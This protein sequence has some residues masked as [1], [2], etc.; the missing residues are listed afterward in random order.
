MAWTIAAKKRLRHRHAQV[1][2]CRQERM[3]NHPGY[4]ADMRPME[5]TVTRFCAVALATVWLTGAPGAAALDMEAVN[6]AEPGAA[7]KSAKSKKA[8]KGIDAVTVKAQILLDRARFSPGEID[9]RDGENMRKALAAFE[10]ANGLEPDG[11]LDADVWARLTETTSEPVLVEYTVTDADV[12][13][14]FAKKIPDKMEDMQDLE[15]LGYRTPL[16][17]LA[18]KFHMSEALMK[19]LN[20]GKKFDKGETIVVARVRT[21]APAGKATRIEIDKAHKTLTVHGKDGPL[22]IYP[23]TIGSKEKPAP[24]GTLKVTSVARNPTY[25]YNPEYAFKSVKSKEP[26]EIRPGPNNPVGAVWIGLSAKGYGIHGTPDP[27]KVSKTESHG[28]IRLTNWDAKELAAMADKGIPVAFL[29]GDADAMASAESDDKPSTQ[30][31][32]RSRRR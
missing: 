2:A 8:A 31:N 17:G 11:K 19:A 28:C 4:L 22:A 6:Q 5:A 29:E 3:P 26:F 21:E 12:K 30:R 7:A 13:G 1:F 27:G 25:R 14:P 16:E 20:P 18:E 15:H 10:R 9:G 23:A 32:R 24:S